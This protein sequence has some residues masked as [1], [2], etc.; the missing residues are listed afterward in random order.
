MSTKFD[1]ISDISYNWFG[2]LYLQE[3]LFFLPRVVGLCPM[4]DT[5]K[6]QRLAGKRQIFTFYQ[7]AKAF[8]KGGHRC[9][10]SQAQRLWEGTTDPRLSTVDRL[11]EV[12]NCE[13]LQITKR[14]ASNGQTHVPRTAKRSQKKR[15]GRGAR[16]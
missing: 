16:K 12:L 8:E 5:E 3:G 10:D 1:V 7:L 15:V 14:P 2:R 11:C 9:S 13:P 4:I 6:L